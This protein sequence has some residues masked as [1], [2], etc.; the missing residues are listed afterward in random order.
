V[1][2]THPDEVKVELSLS[3]PRKH[4][5]GVEVQLY[6]FLTLVLQGVDLSVSLPGCFTPLKNPSTYSMGAWLGPRPDLEVLEKL[7]VSFPYQD[8]VCEL[9]S[10]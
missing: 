7:E 2:S 8:S 4:A 10:P 1:S 9:S 6:Q 5:G 3:M